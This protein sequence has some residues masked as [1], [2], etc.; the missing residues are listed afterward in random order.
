[1][2]S[3]SAFFHNRTLRLGGFWRA[4][5]MLVIVNIASWSLMPG[6]DSQL[7]TYDGLFVRMRSRVFSYLVGKSTICA[8][9]RYQGYEIGGKSDW[10]GSNCWSRIRM[11]F[12]FVREILHIAELS[13]IYY[14]NYKLFANWSM[15]LKQI[16][17]CRRL[18]RSFLCHIDLLS[19]LIYF[20]IFMLPSRDMD[21]IPLKRRK[22]SIQPTNFFIFGIWYSF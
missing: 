8:S 15:S 5:F 9:P 17:D 20:F 6:M 22:S 21:E 18:T 7:L 12:T 3:R 10:L 13:Y 19:I 4:M 2:S 16:S 14:H 11:S 1:M